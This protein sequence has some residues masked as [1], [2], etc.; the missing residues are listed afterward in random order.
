MHVRAALLAALSKALSASLG[1]SYSTAFH[2]SASIAAIVKIVMTPSHPTLGCHR[3]RLMRSTPLAVLG[4][5]LRRF[6]LMSSVLHPS[7]V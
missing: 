1:R 3:A 5:N 4:S 6:V 7:Q 2:G